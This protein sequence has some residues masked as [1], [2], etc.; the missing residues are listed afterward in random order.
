M[1]RFF[2]AA[3]IL[4]L[5]SS[6]SL[7]AGFDEPAGWDDL[8]DGELDVTLFIGQL[9]G[10]VVA[11]GLIDSLG[12]SNT[13]KNDDGMIMGLRVGKDTTYWGWELSFAGAYAD[14]TV[15]D[16]QVTSEG[17]ASWY[18]FNANM[19]LFPAGDDF[20]NGKLQPYIGAGPGLVLY[21]SDSDLVDGD[22]S[23]DMNVAAGTKISLSEGMPDLRIDYRWHFIDGSDMGKHVLK[24]FSVGLCFEF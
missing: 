23:F 8:S 11:S 4:G 6:L 13:V 3:M 9:E 24:E 7:A 10:G 17:D 21:N 5:I 12:E 15:T 18:F 14:E 16:F 22:T 20:A 19:L 1:K 2:S